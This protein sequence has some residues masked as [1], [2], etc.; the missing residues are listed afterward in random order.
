ME[1]MAIES[2]VASVWKL[3]GF[4]SVTRYPVRV[5][6]G[7]SDIDILGLRGDG[8][9][10]VGECKVRGPARRVEIEDSSLRWTQQWDDSLKNIGHIWKSPP[11]WFPS[12]ETLT[13]LEYHLVGNVWFPDEATRIA[14][15]DRLTAVVQSHLPSAFQSRASA[16]VFS[17]AELVSNAIRKVR[18]EVVEENWGKRYGD[19][20]LDALRELVRYAHPRPRGSRGLGQEISRCLQ[21]DL[22]AALF[23]ATPEAETEAHG[24]HD[25]AH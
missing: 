10:R 17:S 1:A 18:I 3:E 6:S 5:R 9:V 22:L 24:E 16:H 19:P 14:A 7:Y 13:G 4:L 15:Q 20:L 11:R 12:L 25:D 8:L 23:A 21:E 2:L